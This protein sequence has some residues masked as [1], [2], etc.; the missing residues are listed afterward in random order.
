MSGPPSRS[1][2]GRTTR[3]RPTRRRPAAAR[4]ALRARRENGLK[5]DIAPTDHAAVMRFTYPGEDAS[6]IFD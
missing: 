2:S 6:V 1:P 5:A 4:R 3:R